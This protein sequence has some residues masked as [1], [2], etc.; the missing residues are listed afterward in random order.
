MPRVACMFTPLSLVT[1]ITYALGT[2]H[3]PN[4]PDVVLVCRG[5][6]C[7][8][9]FRS[10][11][12]GGC[13]SGREELRAT[14][15][16]EE[17]WWFIWLLG[18]GKDGRRRDL[19]QEEDLAAK[20]RR[21][22][23]GFAPFASRWAPG[24][25]AEIQQPQRV[26]DQLLFICSNIEEEDLDQAG[27]WQRRLGIPLPAPSF[28]PRP[29][30]YNTPP[31][32]RMEMMRFQMTTARGSFENTAAAPTQAPGARAPPGPPG[33]RMKMN[34]WMAP[35]PPRVHVAKMKG[36]LRVQTTCPR[37][38]RSTRTPPCWTTRISNRRS[39]PRHLRPCPR[40]TRWRR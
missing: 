23:R 1:V 6:G 36:R 3:S 27:R 32:H 21:R 15:R 18:R 31:P 38:S 5:F 19:A 10:G 29:L 12:I 34:R 9:F 30:S 17:V 24:L 22:G 25:Q 11:E 8:S 33:I 20:E 26:I 14:S 7:F 2:V 13:P 40:A 37:H 16:V 35:S 39:R 4:A 28:S